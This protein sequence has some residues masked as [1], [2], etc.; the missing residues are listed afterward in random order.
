MKKILILSAFTLISIGCGGSAPTQTQTNTNTTT[1]TS[2]SPKKDELT[3]SSHSTENQKPP[4][5]Q[6]NSTSGGSPNQKPVD[7]SAMTA[8]I[9]KAEKD[10]K[11]KPNDD[12]A[13]QALATAYFQRAFALTDAAQY[14]AALGDF[15]KGLKLNPDDKEAK[16]MHDQIVSIYQS[17]G[18]EVPK[19]GEEKAP[20]TTEKK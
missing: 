15:R 2:T 8:A 13:K 16:A 12:K 7:V 1:T 20:A 11:D 5:S 18:R 14:S 17:M 3:V 6:P 9:E 4:M 19:E 10:Y